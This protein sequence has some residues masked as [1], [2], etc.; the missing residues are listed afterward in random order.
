MGALT[1]LQLLKSRGQRAERD[2]RRDGFPHFPKT[3]GHIIPTGKNPMKTSRTALFGAAVAALLLPALVVPSVATATPKNS[4]PTVSVLTSDLEGTTGSAIGP[5]GALYVP[6]GLTGEVTRIDLRTGRT[7]TFA[8]GLPE[9][10]VDI[11]GAI[12]IAFRGRTAYVLVTLVDASVGGSETSGIYRID[13]RDSSTLVADLGT[14][15]IDNPPDTAFDVPS[16]VH[17]AIQTV[18]GG[19]LVSDGHHNRVLFV[20]PRGAI[21]EAITFGNVVPT[22]LAVSGRTAYVSHAGPTPH[23]P[24]DG[25]ILAFRL[26]ADE[27]TARTVAS[28]YS[29]LVD[30]EVNRCGRLFALSQ[31]DGDPGAPEGAPGLPNTGELLTVNRNGTFSVVVDELH[32]PT[33]VEIVRNTAYVVTLAGTVLKVSNVSGKW[34]CRGNG[35]HGR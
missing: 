1:P 20:T 24:E 9:R 25:K 29:L 26:R 7:S 10:V 5:D 35:H 4:Q 15:S 23:L 11:G 22:G 32:W 2:E 17:F 14:W 30:V 34:D 27:P 16:G 18:R 21:S 8:T 13:D 19:F 12:D 6:E 3:S 33:S 28:G 31:G